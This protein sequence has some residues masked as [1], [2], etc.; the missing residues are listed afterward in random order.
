[1]HM[2]M[3]MHM[4]ISANL[5]ASWRISADCGAHTE[6]DG[7]A[8]LGEG[9]GQRAPAAREA[10][11]RF[12]PR[13]AHRAAERQHVDVARGRAYDTRAPD[14]KETRRGEPRQLVWARL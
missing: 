4:H 2:H 5:G 14:A 10:I 12:A 8:E 3:H 13:L 1:M 9:L 11:V 6:E 7:I